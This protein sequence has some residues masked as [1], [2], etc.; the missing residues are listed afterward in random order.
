[1]PTIVQDNINFSIN[2]DTVF[3]KNGKYTHGS[4]TDGNKFDAEYFAENPNDLAKSFNAIE[5]DWNGSQVCGRT[6]NTTGDFLVLLSYLAKR[7]D[8][9]EEEYNNKLNSKYPID[10]IVEPTNC[11]LFTN[12][13]NN[14]IQL[15]ITPIYK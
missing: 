13:T 15:I 1:M 4:N 6:I 9:L 5:I 12:D 7:A 8:E 11:E 10:F 14:S 2:P 3:S